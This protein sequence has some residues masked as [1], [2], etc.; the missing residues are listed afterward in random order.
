MKQ[1][2]LTVLFIL[3]MALNVFAG[4]SALSLDV[5][6]NAY[7]RVTGYGGVAMGDDI[8][9]ISYNPAVVAHI[10]SISG[11]L[12]HLNY[13]E[14]VGMLYGNFVYPM[15]KFNIA[16]RFGYL[17]MPSIIDNQTGEELGYSEFFF[18]A[19]SAYQLHKRISAGANINFY[20]A[21]IANTSGST[22][23]VNA[24]AQ[25][26]TDL[27]ITG[28]H[29]LIIGGSVLNLGPGIKFIE[30]PCALPLNFNLGL[31]YIYDRD[32][33]LFLGLRKAMDTESLL[34]SLGGELD[35]FRFLSVRM[36][37]Y[38]DL[39]EQLKFNMGVGFKISYSGYDF[40]L[41]YTSLPLEEIEYSQIITLTFRF[42]V[43]G[44]TEEREEDWGN[45]WE[46]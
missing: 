22:F 42:P 19:G 5:S 2:A 39:N 9:G 26:M 11:T 17:Y 4:T 23:F 3:L 16:G 33:R 28:Y 21:K 13:V 41:D 15:E 24:G 30:D 7:E 32:Y 44:K 46:K 34:W 10:R 36:S 40:L 14:D 43:E 6:A 8:G 27:P 35:L 25:Y 18:G 45:I 1:I 31:K 20:T 12:T 38:K 29:K 37:G